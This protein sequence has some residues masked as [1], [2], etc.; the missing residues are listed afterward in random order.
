MV[1]LGLAQRRGDKQ[2]VEEF[3]CPAPSKLRGYPSLR[4]RSAR[5]ES[6]GLRWPRQGSFLLRKCPLLD[7]G[8]TRRKGYSHLD[9]W[10]LPR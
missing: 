9:L 8:S 7:K 6:L 10:N 3:Q 5:I 2:R 4:R 1:S